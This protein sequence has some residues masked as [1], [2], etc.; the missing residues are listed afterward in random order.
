[1]CGLPAYER[2]EILQAVNAPGFSYWLREENLV[3]DYT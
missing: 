1:V 2:T 3:K